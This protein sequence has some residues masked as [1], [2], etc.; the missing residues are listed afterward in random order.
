[1]FFILS[2]TGPRIDIAAD[3]IK[4]TRDIVSLNYQQLVGDTKE[5]I[6]D[7]AGVTFQAFPSN[8]GGALKIA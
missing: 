5:V 6:A 7:I 4:R 2:L 3:L 8:I 1:L